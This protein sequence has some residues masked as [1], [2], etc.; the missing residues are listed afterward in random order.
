MNLSIM[1]S[2]RAVVAALLILSA[3]AAAMQSFAQFAARNRVSTL[4]GG[5]TAVLGTYYAAKA[6]FASRQPAPVQNALVPASNS[7]LSYVPGSNLLANV[8]AV[9]QRSPA[10]NPALQAPAAAPTTTTAAPAAQPTHRGGYSGNRGGRGGFRGGYRGGHASTNP[11]NVQPAPTT[12]TTTTTV[13]PVAQPTSYAVPLQQQQQQQ[14]GYPV[15]PQ[16]LPTTTT[17]TVPKQAP[18]ADELVQLLGGFNNWRQQCL[19]LPICN[20]DKAAAPQR[21]PVIVAGPVV[22]QI[23]QEFKRVMYVELVSGKFVAAPDAQNQMRTGQQQL[24]NFFADQ[25]KPLGSHA[26]MPFV[27]KKICQ[28]RVECISSSD[29]HGDIHELLALLWSAV[30]NNFTLQDINAVYVFDGDMVDCGWYGIEVLVTLMMLKIKNPE[31]VIIIRGNHED[32]FMNTKPNA[33]YYTFGQELAAKYNDPALATEIYSSYER[34]PLAAFVGIP[35]YQNK[36]VDYTLFVHGWFELGFN[37]VWL[38]NDANAQFAFVLGHMNRK[39]TLEKMLK[40]LVETR[41][42]TQAEADAFVAATKWDDYYVNS[43]RHLNQIAYCYGD[44]TMTEKLGVCNTNYPGINAFGWVLIKAYF[45][46]YN[47]I[48]AKHSDQYGFVHRLCLVVRGHQHSPM[49][50]KM[51]QPEPLFNQICRNKYGYAT[52]YPIILEQSQSCNDKY[53]GTV[54]SLWSASHNEIYNHCPVPNQHLR[55]NKRSVARI[56]MEPGFA[57]WTIQ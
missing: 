29:Y 9:L 34:M 39:S 36:V 16:A 32:A 47:D 13:T 56:T 2:S 54:I 24:F 14:M 27:Q 35:D 15:Y 43:W 51:N 6:Y 19:N 20:G 31:Q 1:R 50:L 40:P 30:N 26:L 7:W 53:I 52:I 12:T 48:A 46:F 45:D 22:Q 41:R 28:G 3:D 11:A 42:I 37:H 17:T 5:A 55:S 21:L 10:N 57:N 23:I 18:M 8:A 44:Y 25:Q 38:L 33:Q 4:V 49:N